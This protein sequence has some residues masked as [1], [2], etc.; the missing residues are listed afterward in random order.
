MPGRIETTP[1]GLK[2][3][4]IDHTKN[5]G[6]PL[7]LNVTATEN[8]REVAGRSSDNVPKALYLQCTGKPPRALAG[9]AFKV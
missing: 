6:N 7:L 2:D 8:L 9:F 4:D 3:P 5:K 1:E